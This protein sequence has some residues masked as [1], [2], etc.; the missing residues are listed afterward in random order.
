MFAGDVD[1]KTWYKPEIDKKILKELSKRSDKKGIID[2][3]IFILAIIVSGYLCVVTWG[4][5]WCIPALLLYGNIFYCKVISI[6]HETNHETYFKS[7]RLNRIFYNIT[8]MVLKDKII[9]DFFTV[10]P[11]M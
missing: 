10:L 8:S 11:F 1:L 9:K 7:R 6:Q 4:T 2:I 3:S 5:F